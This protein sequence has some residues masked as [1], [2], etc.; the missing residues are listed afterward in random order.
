MGNTLSELMRNA[1]IGGMLV[2][3]VASYFGVFVVQRRMAFLGSGLAHAA[4]GGIALALFANI[5]PIYIA[6]PF[7]VVFAIAIVWIRENSV[8]AEDT[9][10]GV[11]VAVA[12]ALGIVF[13]QFKDNFADAQ[14]YLF[15]SILYISGPELAMAIA[16]ACVTLATLPLWSAWAYATFDR[17]LAQTDRLKV[18]MHDYTLAVALAVAIVVSI[19]LAGILLISTFLVLPAATARLLSRSFLQMAVVSVL[20]GTLTPAAG[21]YLSMI[22]DWPPSATI[23]FLQA[24][25]FVVALGVRRVAQ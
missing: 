1:L 23:I 11:A 2:G 13:L 22:P 21:F 14:A 4:F 7:T 18:R 6:I 5:E 3:F 24:A 17:S 9:A 16:M 8:L 25:L 15:G 10:I 20:I 12:M 19:K